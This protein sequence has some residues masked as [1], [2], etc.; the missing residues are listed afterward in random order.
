MAT[1]FGRREVRTAERPPIYP[2][3]YPPSFTDHVR[4]THLLTVDR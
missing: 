3:F 4:H 1:D 2:I